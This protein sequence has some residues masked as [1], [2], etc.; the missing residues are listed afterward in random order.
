VIKL[1]LEAYNG[2]DISDY[3]HSSV[4]ELE[5]RTFPIHLRNEI[6]KALI[7]GSNGMFLWVF[8]ILFDLKTSTDSSPFAIR[9]KLKSL[10]EDLP[11]LYNRILLNINV[12][13]V[14]AA[15]NIL[16]WVVW[17]KRPLSLQELKIAVAI[18]PEQTSM[19]KISETMR[20][21]LETDLY[22]ILGPLIDIRDGLVYL[23]HQSAKAYLKNM[24]P[25]ACNAISAL[26]DESNLYIST[27]C[28]AYLSF[29][30]FHHEP[31]DHGSFST[32]KGLT[33]IRRRCEEFPFLLYCG[34]HW[35]YHVRQLDEK[36]HATPLLLN[37]FL[38]LATSK[39]KF[40]LWHEIYNSSKNRFFRYMDPF[41]ITINFGLICFLQALLDNEGSV[42]SRVNADETPLLMAIEH[43]NDTIVRYLVDNGADVNAQGGRYG[44]PLQAA[45]TED[46]G[47]VRYLVEN[48]ASV[49]ARDGLY[50]S[51]LQAAATKDIEI[52]RYLV[53]KGADVNTQGGYYGN[54]LQAAAT[55]DVEIVRYLVG[56][57][58]DVNAQGGYYGNPLQAAATKDIEIVRFLVENGADVNAQGGIYGS[59]LQAA[60]AHRLEKTVRYLV[61]NLADVNAQ[62][63]LYGSPLQAASAHVLEDRV[64]HLVENRAGINA[65]DSL[66][67]GPLNATATQDFEIL[68]YLVENGAGINPQG[69][70]YSN[71]LSAA[72]AKDHNRIV[73]FLLEHGATRITKDGS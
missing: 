35:H 46:A 25:I 60:S 22:S 63:G 33:E 2:K 31:V 55:K 58:A 61:K 67:G 28:L 12:D 39:Q 24:K 64:H 59:P 17:A 56:K 15:N 13:D 10:P 26:S 9:K 6:K 73:R 68:R 40:N 72:K 20:C 49:N 23:V 52:V 18:R 1:S 16:R 19:S 30:E 14:E 32:N 66:Y 50:G 3:V 29:D 62:G 21:D 70:G 37:M 8:L 27:C 41:E 44:N 34:M 71:T 47:I 57:G 48:G 69:G 11:N 36:L 42:E 65:Q 5:K 45:A 38:R 53:G 54:P 7:E 4:D 51:P 43:G